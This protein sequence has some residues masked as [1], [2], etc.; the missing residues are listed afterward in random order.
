MT[1]F[2]GNQN[3]ASSQNEWKR[4]ATD[5]SLALQHGVNQWTEVIPQNAG[6][7][8]TAERLAAQHG[9]APPKGAV[10]GANQYRQKGK[11]FPSADASPA[12]EAGG[13]DGQDFVSKWH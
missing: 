8:N 7:P 1:G 10:V 11:N 4:I 13:A 2:K 5:E 6:Q 9:V 12:Q 3:T